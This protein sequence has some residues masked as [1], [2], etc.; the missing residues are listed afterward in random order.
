VVS[1]IDSTDQ[2][3]VAVTVYVCIREVLGSK[4]DLDIGHP[5]RGVLWFSLVPAGKFGE[6][7]QIMARLFFF[8]ILYSS[9][10]ASHTT[11]H[12]IECTGYID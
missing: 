9:L 1:Y 8:Q 12:Y 2:V 11:R 4:P 3:G 6:N 7:T 5:D 10:F